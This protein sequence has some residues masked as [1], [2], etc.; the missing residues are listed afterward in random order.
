MDGCFATQNFGA[1]IMGIGVFVGGTDITTA[2]SCSTGNPNLN[3]WD[4]TANSNTASWTT[5]VDGFPPR[6]DGG[7]NMPA[8]CGVNY[9]GLLPGNAGAVAQA[10]IDS[11]V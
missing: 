8:V 10:I 6:S 11:L 2:P 9:F 5:T 3:I 4:C 7:N 1:G